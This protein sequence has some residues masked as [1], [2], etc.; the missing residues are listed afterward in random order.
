MLDTVEGSGALEAS[1]V[2]FSSFHIGD[3]VSFFC[4]RQRRF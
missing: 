2:A 1:G 4:R 3:G